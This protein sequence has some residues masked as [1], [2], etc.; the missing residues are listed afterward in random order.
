MLTDRPVHRQR[1]RRFARAPA[2]AYD[3]HHIFEV[4]NDVLFGHTATL[5]E[6]RNVSIRFVTIG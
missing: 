6:L 2:T 4:G 3:Q 5:P 1:P